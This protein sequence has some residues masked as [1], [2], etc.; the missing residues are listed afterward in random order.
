MASKSKRKGKKGEREI[1]KILTEKFNEPFMRVPSSG[2]YVGGLNQ[3]RRQILD[4][5]QIR[6]AKADIIP[7]DSMPKMVIEVKNYANFP[8]HTLVFGKP[9]RYLD[10]W[11]KELTD[12]MDP[13]DVGFLIFKIDN[14]GTH[15]CFRYDIFE[16]VIT[17]NIGNHTEYNEWWVCGLEMFLTE[18]N[19]KQIRKIC[20]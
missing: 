3:A 15:I 7:P 14:Q 4:Q 2:A 19:I 13:G 5:G 12:D 8:F 16:N 18:E 9:V 11:L 10:E 20:A 6:G 1:C 17:F